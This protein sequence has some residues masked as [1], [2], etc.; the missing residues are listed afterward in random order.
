MPLSKNE[1]R[2]LYDSIYTDLLDLSD[3]IKKLLEI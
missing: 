1:E 2:T 3:D